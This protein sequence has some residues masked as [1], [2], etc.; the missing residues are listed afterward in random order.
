MGLNTSLSFIQIA[1]SLAPNGSLD[2]E[3]N[4]PAKKGKSAKAVSPSPTFIRGFF[5][6]S[7]FSYIINSPGPGLKVLA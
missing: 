6:V 3:Y 4:S 1:P 2:C 5:T 7:S